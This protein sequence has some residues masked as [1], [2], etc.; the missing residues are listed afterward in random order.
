VF[1]NDV[2]DVQGAGSVETRSGAQG[3]AWQAAPTMHTYGSQ[4][5]H[6]R[7]AKLQVVCTS[8]YAHISPPFENSETDVASQSDNMSTVAAV[9]ALVV[10]AVRA[11]HVPTPA[12]PPFDTWRV[13]HGVTDVSP[14][15]EAA[16][17]A[18]CKRWDVSNRV[19]GGARC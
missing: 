13:E 9:L 15:A 16:F 19:A 18:N 8:G 7:L 17:N 1:A 2:V 12:C 11:A 6:A 3:L 10:C 5:N 4:M 14:G